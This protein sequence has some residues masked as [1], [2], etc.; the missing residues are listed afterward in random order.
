MSRPC[1]AAASPLSEEDEALYQ[2]IAAL[3]GVLNIDLFTREHFDSKPTEC[4]ASATLPRRAELPL[5][6]CQ[7]SSAKG[8]R[9]SRVEDVVV[10]LDSAV[11]LTMLNSVDHA[12]RGRVPPEQRPDA[13]AVEV[14]YR[15]K[16]ASDDCGAARRTA[17]KCTPP[18]GAVVKKDAAANEDDD[19]LSE[20]S[21]RP[22][23]RRT[24]IGST[25]TGS[26]IEPPTWHYSIDMAYQGR[27]VREPS[28]GTS[29][30]SGAS[31]P[32]C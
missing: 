16:S 30:S 26:S 21:T 14:H 32:R 2:E 20:C 3:T 1:F 15:K 29:V 10:G 31:S 11:A 27:M 8:G 5:K 28:E 19:S 6:D 4:T 24:T 7:P 17:I 9:R 25:S 23:S 18:G 12:Y 13:S 22:G